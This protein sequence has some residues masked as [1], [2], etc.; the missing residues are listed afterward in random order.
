MSF[1]DRRR[2]WQGGEMVVTDGEFLWPDALP[3]EISAKNI[4]WT[5]SYLQP[6]TDS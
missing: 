6:S 2:G 1:S 5:S 3:D 4:H